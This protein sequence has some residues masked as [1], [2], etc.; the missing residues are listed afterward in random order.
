MTAEQELPGPLGTDHL[1]SRIGLAIVEDG[2]GRAL[3]MDPA[4]VLLDGAGH[5]SF[6]ALGMLFDLAS[7]TAHGP[8]QMRPFVHADITINR[9]RPPIGAVYATARLAREGKRTG[10]VEIDLRDR[11]GALVATSTQEV[12][13]RDPPPGSGI[14][15]GPEDVQRMRKMFQERFDGTC[16]LD[17]PLE[18]TLGIEEIDGGWQIPPGLDRT[19]GFGGMHGGTAITVV[20]VAA[21]QSVAQR[22]GRPARTLS[23][24]VRYLSPARVGPFVARPEILVDDDAVAVVRVPVLDSGQ[25][26]RLVIL[27]DVHVTRA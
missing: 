12:V 27:A 16:R 17:R 10:V 18:E 25:D 15:L 4:P 24:A 5:L 11:T 20:D 8:S 1:L 9:L 6:G 7:S 23:A 26:D 13:Y 19:N 3:T 22:W 14:G 2:P 21:S